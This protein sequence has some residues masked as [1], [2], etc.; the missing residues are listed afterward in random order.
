MLPDVEGALP[1]WVAAFYKR[2][3]DIL[4][5]PL[6]WKIAVILAGYLFAAINL[7]VDPSEISTLPE[8]ANP[9]S[10]SRIK[11]GGFAFITA[12]ALFAGLIPTGTKEQDKL[13]DATARFLGVL[14]AFGAGWYVLDSETHGNPGLYILGIAILAGFAVI[15]VIISGGLCVALLTVLNALVF[16]LR[17]VRRFLGTNTRSLVGRIRKIYLPGD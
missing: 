10:A 4:R 15:V 2:L 14:T 11:A 13:V 8:D 5:D 3:T 7:A 16:T 6:W 12:I 9:Y 1:N 17:A